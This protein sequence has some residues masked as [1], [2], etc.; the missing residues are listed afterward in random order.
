MLKFTYTGSPG[1]EF[2]FP[3]RA[4][5]PSP[6]ETI[7]LSAAE[8]ETVGPDVFKPVKPKTNAATADTEGA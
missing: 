8:A 5:T 7:E 4:I 2:L 1:Y 6:G 3:E